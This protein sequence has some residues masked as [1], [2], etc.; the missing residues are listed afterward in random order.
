LY[1]SY[2]LVVL[3]KTQPQ[4]K[5]K[6]ATEALIKYSRADSGTYWYNG[7]IT[8]TLTFEKE[9]EGSCVYEEIY[10]SNLIGSGTEIEEGTF[11]IN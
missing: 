9:K 4:I 8:I 6:S 3:K 2:K 10:T 11:M 7:S 1:F 5:K